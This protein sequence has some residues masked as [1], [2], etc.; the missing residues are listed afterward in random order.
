MPRTI[1]AKFRHIP[2]A[3]RCMTAINSSPLWIARTIAE[4]T[5]TMSTAVAWARVGKRT[6]GTVPAQIAGACAIKTRP[7]IRTIHGA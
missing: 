4:G 5:H 7:V 1:H 3:I 2:W 6:I